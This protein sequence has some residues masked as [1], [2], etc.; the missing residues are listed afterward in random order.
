MGKP[1]RRVARYLFVECP[2][3]GQ[4]EKPEWF[5]Y[6]DLCGDGLPA[7]D[8]K[9][10]P[11]RGTPAEPLL[12]E[13]PEWAGPAAYLFEPHT[14]RGWGYATVSLKTKKIKGLH[15]NDFIVATK[16]DRLAR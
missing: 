4:V 11:N 3:P 10:R 15:E 13:H 2:P 6:P 12:A 1:Q 8:E 14:D 7:W 16:I 9:H 5:G